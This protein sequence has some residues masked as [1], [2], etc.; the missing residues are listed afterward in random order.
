MLKAKRQLRIGDKVYVAGDV[1]PPLPSAEEKRLISL[2][3][4]VIIEEVPVEEEHD[5]L[6]EKP[7][8]KG[9]KK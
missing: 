2:S 3:A 9:R 6:P 8:Q 5:D 4:A 7:K 1:L